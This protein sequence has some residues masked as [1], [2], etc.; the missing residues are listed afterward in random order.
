MGSN[1]S[2]ETMPEQRRDIEASHPASV[3]TQHEEEEKARLNEL[4]HRLLI[5]GLVISTSLMLIGLGLDLFL[6]RDTP[7]TA[8]DLTEALQQAVDLNPSGFLTLGL[9]VLIATP[10]LRVIGSVLAFIYERDW[11]YALITFLVFTIVMI[12]IISGKG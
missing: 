4:V 10:I 5:I 2:E 7:K 12:S 1:L 6:H 3:E 11:R 9:L 8:L